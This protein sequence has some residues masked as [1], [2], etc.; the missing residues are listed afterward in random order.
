MEEVWSESMMLTT[1]FTVPEMALKVVDRAI[2]VHGAEGICQDTPLAYFYASLRTLR[3]AD[4]RPHLLSICP[5][6]YFCRL[7]VVDVDADDKGPDEVHIQQQGKQ[8]L[9][10]LPML[11][12]RYDKI[13]EKSS[14]LLGDQVKAKL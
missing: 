10:R 11:R 1:Q 4:V 2:Q 8:E 13:R 5:S 6:L 14:R 12:E 7:N 3:F 9:K